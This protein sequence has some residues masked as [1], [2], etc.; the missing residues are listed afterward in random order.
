MITNLIEDLLDLAKMENSVF[1]LNN[2]YFNLIDVITEAFNIVS[3]SAEEKNV[4]LLLVVDR[5]KPF[6]FQK[7]YSDKRRF[8]QILL[9]FISNSLKFVKKKDGFL[10]VHLKAGEEQITENQIFPSKRPKHMDQSRTPY[11]KLAGEQNANADRAPRARRLQSMEPMKRENEFDER[12]FEEVHKY[13]QIQL[14]VEDNGT[15]ISKEGQAKLFMD[16]NKLQENEKSNTQGTGLGL[17][18]CKKIIESMGGRI[19]VDSAGKD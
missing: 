2:D 17:S 9:N 5:S 7:V 6:I 1:K 11:A 16:Y 12:A 13:I 19:K 3:F 4:K 10:K 14:I 15:G 18:I 8:L